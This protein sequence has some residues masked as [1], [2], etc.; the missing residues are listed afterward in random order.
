MLFDE[1][2]GTVSMIPKPV[3]PGTGDGTTG[4]TVVE[5]P[6]GGTKR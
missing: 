5:I 1:A 4:G 2:A 3:A 6:G